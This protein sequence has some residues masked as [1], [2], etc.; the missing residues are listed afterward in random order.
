[1][2]TRKYNEGGMA[3]TSADSELDDSC[4]ETYTGSD[5][6]RRRRRKSGCR[7][8]TKS[9]RRS[10]PEPVK[11]VIKAA[12]TGAGAVVAYLQKQKIGEGIE[13]LLGSKQMGG[14]TNYKTGGMVNANANLK[15]T[16][17]AGSKGVKHG[18]NPK[19][20]ASSTVKKPSAARSKAPKKATPGKR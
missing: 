1:M 5:G 6:K 2:A 14:S 9:G 10:I 11:K 19:A 20:T 17:S 12:G 8:K 16:K 7:K 3:S 13:K 4:M 15:A 18:V